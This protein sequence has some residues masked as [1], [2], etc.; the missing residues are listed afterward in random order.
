[1]IGDKIVPNE[2]HTSAAK[3][4]YEHMTGSELSLPVAITIAGESGAGKS[5]IA[6]ELKRF[7]EERGHR[8]FIF[9]QDD[10]FF[11]PP[12][13]NEAARRDDIEHVGLGEV[14]MALLDEHL[15]AFKNEATGELVKPLVIF[16]EDRVTKETIAPRDFEVAIAEG[17]YTTILEHGDHHVFIDR[18]HEETLS[19]RR[20]RQRDPLDEFIERV[21][22][23]EHE[24]ISGH[25]TLADVIVNS[26]YSV[27][28]VTK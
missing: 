25:K 7:L 21:L 9:Q 2:H 12:K 8:V 4:V 17:T 23:I 16:A 15:A 10:Y 18:T 1:M 5:E 22:E 28:P 24:I 19:H 20:E 14:N 13:T 27:T 11:L 6:V 26:D 3:A